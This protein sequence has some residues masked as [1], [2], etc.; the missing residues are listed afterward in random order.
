MFVLPEV[1][2]L[3][4][5]LPVLGS[6]AVFRTKMDYDYCFKF[7]LIGDSGVGKSCLLLNLIEKRFKDEH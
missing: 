5:S 7:I 3:E 2:I 6:M 4:M 1:A